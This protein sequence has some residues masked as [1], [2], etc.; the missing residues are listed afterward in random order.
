VANLNWKNIKIIVVDPFLPK[1]V[2]GRDQGK[3]A[4]ADFDGDSLIACG[5]D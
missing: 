3:F 1:Q 4:F 2:V 5:A